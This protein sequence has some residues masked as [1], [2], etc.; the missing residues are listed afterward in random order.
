VADAVGRPMRLRPLGEE[1]ARGA[2]LLA[3][4]RL[5]AIDDAVA[6]AAAERDDAVRP[7]GG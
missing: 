3:L 4:E 7:V 6:F 5:G 1:T 2:A